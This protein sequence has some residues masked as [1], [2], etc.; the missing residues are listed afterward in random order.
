MI[1]EVKITDDGNT[2]E[3]YTEDRIYWLE[4]RHLE[5]LAW[6]ANELD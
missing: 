6:Y 4:A 5:Q 2:I 3:V 1:V